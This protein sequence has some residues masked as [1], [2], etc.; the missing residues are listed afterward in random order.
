ML[1]LIT[2]GTLKQ[3]RDILHRH[4]YCSRNKIVAKYTINIRPV[5]RI[6]EAKAVYQG[7]YIDCCVCS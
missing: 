6:D 7:G 3:D 5:D 2:F 1:R 4:E